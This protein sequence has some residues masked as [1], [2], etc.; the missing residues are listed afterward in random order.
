VQTLS[1]VWGVLAFLGMLVGFLPCLGA[2]N[3]LNIPFAAVGL[4]LGVIAVVNSK[5]RNN[6]PAI[7]GIVGC[8]IAVVIGLLRLKLGAGVL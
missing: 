4:I 6:G 7:A 3:W 8:A 2:L 5:T 1:L